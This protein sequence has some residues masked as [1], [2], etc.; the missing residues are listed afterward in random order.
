MA[1]CMTKAG[2]AGGTA[3]IIQDSGPAL[4]SSFALQ[5]KCDDC[6][7]KIAS[8]RMTLLCQA[9][10]GETPELGRLP[11]RIEKAPARHRSYVACS[12]TIKC[13]P[14]GGNSTRAGDAMTQE[15]PSKSSQQCFTESTS[16]PNSSTATEQTASTT[17]TWP[18]Q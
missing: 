4:V 14:G 2:A 8:R 17:H 5:K 3:T 13:L 12:G 1:L 11:T 7:Y 15:W 6:A 10:R 18:V 16:L 9:L